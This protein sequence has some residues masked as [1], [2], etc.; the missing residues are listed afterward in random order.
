MW[1]FRR[2]WI[3]PLILILLVLVVFA[4]F[5]TGEKSAVQ[6][7]PDFILEVKAGNVRSAEVDGRDIT[8]TLENDPITYKTTV[9]RGDTLRQVLQDAGIQPEDFPPYEIKEL[10][11]WGNVLGLFLNFLP[12]IIILGVIFYFVR[13]ASRPQPPAI[14]KTPLDPVCGKA[15]DPR[16]SYGSSTFQDVTYYFCSPEHKNEFDNDPVRYLLKK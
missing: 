11:R 16:A 7:L 5:S 12:I 10:S 15:I 6:S 8:Y 3:Y 14:Q 1:L 9:E 2:W 4:T 13:R